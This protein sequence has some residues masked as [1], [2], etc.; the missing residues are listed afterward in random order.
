ML[1]RSFTAGSRFEFFC[2]LFKYTRQEIT[3][4][5]GNK[6]GVVKSYGVLPLGLFPVFQYGHSPTSTVNMLFGVYSYQADYR[7]EEGQLS[8]FI[9]LYLRYW[10]RE[11]T[12]QWYLGPLF[13]YKR[14]TPEKSRSFSILALPYAERWR[15]FGV[16]SK[17]DDF[18]LEFHPLFQY[19]IE[20][21]LS[22]FHI[23]YGLFGLY[24][25]RPAGKPKSEA[26]RRFRILWFIS[27]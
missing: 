6:K 18:F 17:K 15:L 9:L 2:L 23:L 21:G 20:D 5:A 27:F 4:R 13:R 22:R 14:N 19:K 3:D 1:F 16:G 8:L 7:K 10:D 12:T 26:V 25:E 11:S 24:H